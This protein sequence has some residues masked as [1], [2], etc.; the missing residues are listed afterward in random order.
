MKNRALFRT[1]VIW[2]SVLMYFMAPLVGT[3]SLVICFG[4]DGHIKVEIASIGFHCGKSS[5]NTPQSTSYTHS[6]LG[7]NSTKAHCSS[8][9]DIPFFP[10]FL[11]R[12][13]ST[14][15]NRV[16]LVKDSLISAFSFV[17]STF[18]RMAASDLSLQPLISN[19]SSLA[20]IRTV[21]L[22]I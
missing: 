16:P 2:L 3:D 14:A 5:D 20:F 22:L 18:A 1:S 12:C 21:I 9:I 10:Y 8:C 6:M 17:P 13:V 7:D 19:N 4:S 15:Q 11:N